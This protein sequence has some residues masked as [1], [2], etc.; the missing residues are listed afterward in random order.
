MSQL[1]IHANLV[2][3]QNIVQTRKCDAVQTRKC[4]ANADV[5]GIRTKTNMF[6]SHETNGHN[7]YFGSRFLPVRVDLFL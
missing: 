6:P 4:D 5:N 3:S 7:T 2:G 1:Y